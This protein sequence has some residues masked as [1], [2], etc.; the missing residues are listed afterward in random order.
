MLAFVIQHRFW[1]A[2]VLY[3]IFSAAVSSMP[4]SPANGAPIYVWLFRFV[5]TVAGNIT[6]A[7]GKQDSRSES[8]VSSDRCSAPH[9]RFGLRC[10]PL[11]RS[12]GCSG[13]ARFLGLRHIARRADEQSTDDFIT[14]VLE[15]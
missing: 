3:W 13:P 11:H 15:V 6:T 2:V 5:H 4:D 8:T 1:V 9:L 12:S 14:A 10:R 7:F